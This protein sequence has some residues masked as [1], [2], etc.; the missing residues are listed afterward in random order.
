MSGK[1]VSE[2]DDTHTGGPYLG[3]LCQSHQR[4]VSSPGPACYCDTVGID[5]AGRFEVVYSC[6]QIFEISSAGILSERFHEFTAEACRSAE[7]GSD[8]NIS[9]ARVVLH[10][11]EPAVE[12]FP[13]RS[14]VRIDDG[15]V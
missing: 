14:P 2:R 1:P 7:V 15:R 6:D 3:I 4:K 11:G 8:H 5:V 13:L 9:V 12:V 10:A